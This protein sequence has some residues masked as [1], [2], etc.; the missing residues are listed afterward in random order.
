MISFYVIAV[1]FGGG[2]AILT[3]L[4]IKRERN[5]GRT[6]PLERAFPS[7]MIFL[8]AGILI[9]VGV[10]WVIDTYELYQKFAGPL[11]AFLAIVLT[12]PI[13]LLSVG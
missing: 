12:L 3:W 6:S 9:L 8:A 2:I 13:C 1:L 7:F 5:S 11:L 10:A 4:S